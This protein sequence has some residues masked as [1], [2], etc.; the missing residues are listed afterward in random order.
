MLPVRSDT[1]SMRVKNR[2]AKTNT[3]VARIY[4][5]IA[6]Y[7][8]VMVP[9]RELDYPKAGHNPLLSGMNL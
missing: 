2:M 7:T 9:G 6:I 5:L 8:S 4:G 1:R 3:T